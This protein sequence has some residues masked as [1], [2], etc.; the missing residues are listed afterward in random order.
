MYPYAASGTGLSALLPPWADADGRLYQNLADPA[1]RAKIRAGRCS[2][3]A[4]DWEA[5]GT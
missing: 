1:M 5:M 2:S 4:G 3:P